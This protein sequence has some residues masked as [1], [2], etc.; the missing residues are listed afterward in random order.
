MTKCRY[1]PHITLKTYTGYP[2]NTRHSSMNSNGPFVLPDMP[3]MTDLQHKPITAA[4]SLL[5]AHTILAE[6]IIK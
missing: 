2:Q 5:Q 6:N 1:K 3:K 4:E